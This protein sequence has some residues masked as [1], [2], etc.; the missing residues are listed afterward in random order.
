MQDL[1][2]HDMGSGVRAPIA[3]R[4][5]PRRRGGRALLS[6]GVLL[7][8][9]A[10]VGCENRQ[11]A[12]ISLNH[13]A[14]A[15][16]GLGVYYRMTGEP[17]YKSA[18]V[19]GNLDRFGIEAQL[20]TQGDLEAQV[21]AYA[22]DIP[23]SLSSG[24]GTVHLPGEY[25]QNLTIDMNS[26]TNTCVGGTEPAGFPTGKMAVWARAANDI[27]LAGD[28]GK[29][30]HWDGDR[31]TRMTLPGDL[32][33]TPP[34]WNAI[35]GTV[36][37]DVFF[38]GT[39]GSVVRWTGNVLEQLTVLPPSGVVLS[40][41]SWRDIA[42]N[43]PTQ[44][45]LWLAGT[46]GVF[47][48]YNVGQ[49]ASTV[50]SSLFECALVLNGPVT[51]FR[52]NVN[53]V[54]C[55]LVPVGGVATPDCWYAADAGNILRY[56]LPTGAGKPNCYLYPVSGVTENL[57]GIWAGVNATLS[58]LDVRVVGAKNTILRGTA[59]L[60]PTIP[61]PAFQS[62][63][64]Y[65][66]PSFAA[67]MSNFGGIS[68]APDTAGGNSSTVVWVAG[69]GGVVLRWDDTPQNPGA[70]IPFALMNT[71]SKANFERVSGLAGGAMAAGPGSAL[72][73]AGSLFTAM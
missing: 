47:G 50:S 5:T 16:T 56:S 33:K 23:C 63:A 31:Y 59:A 55:A 18:G 30:L 34:T 25:R 7:W 41:L 71:G 40:N 48:Y 38:V 9:A 57:Q 70:Q 67:N 15:S 17:T 21:F 54:S 8:A 45:D 3:N 28:G 68:S 12:V 20:G 51:S 72:F 6:A 1:C 29:I 64:G 66:A 24:N 36:R 49:G 19:R 69:S 2:S 26:T 46:G 73:Y 35:T 14:P 39:S 13:R 53:G 61:Y 10:T 11:V 42:V 62:Y 22:N 44:G 32:A 37:G 60:G 27:W 43:Q 52:Q 58:A 65:L 4:F